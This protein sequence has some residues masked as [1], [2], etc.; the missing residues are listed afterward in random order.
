M[1]MP[2]RRL[3]LMV[4]GALALAL[5]SASASGAT[6]SAKPKPA[7]GKPITVL[8]FGPQTGAG[9]FIAPSTNVYKVALANINKNGGINGRP[10]AAKVVD[11]QL[12]SAQAVALYNQYA[13]SAPAIFAITSPEIAAIGPLAIRD[14]I[15]VVTESSNGAIIS[16]GRPYV[17]GITPNTAAVG[18]SAAQA[19]LKAQPDLAHGPV[20]I[21]YQQGASISVGQVGPAG[22]WLSAHG[23]TANT[24]NYAAGTTDFSSAVSKIRGM[25]PT[26]VI[27]SGPP[28]DAVSIKTQLSVQGMG[29]IPVLL[30]PVVGAAGYLAL[31]GRK[32]L[33]DY[34]YNYYWS[35]NPLLLKVPWVANFPT[36]SGTGSVATATAFEV[37][38]AF[39][40]LASAMSAAHVDKLSSVSAQ[41]AAIQKRLPKLSVKRIDGRPLTFGSDG[42]AGASGYLLQIAP[43]SGAAYEQLIAILK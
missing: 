26:G 27:I 40:L 43:K 12:V 19:W 4:A 35:S 28:A 22:D 32:A 39:H 9:A 11:S 14:K 1:I 17:W 13:S 10:L 6:S 38:D 18:A 3:P 33:G 36:T 37:W 30:D 7:H 20:A 21:V 2:K 23:V 8:F 29:D 5:L 42:I 34:A 24:V 41:R 16:A 25:N 31:F 15:P